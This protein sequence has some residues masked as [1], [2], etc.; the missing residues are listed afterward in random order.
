MEGVYNYDI[1]SS[2]TTGLRQ[3]AE[4]LQAVGCSVDTEALDKY[5]ERGGKDWV[6]DN[7][8]LD[9]NLV[10]RVEHAI[11]FGAS[12]PASMRQA[13]YKKYK[14]AWGM[15]EIAQHVDEFYEGRET[16]DR[17]LKDLNE[18]FGPQV[19]MIEDLAQG[20]LN[21]YWSAHSQ[22][23]G[24]GMGRFMRNHAGITFCKH[25]HKEKIFSN[26]EVIGYRYGHEARARV[27]AWY[28]Q[29]LE[30]AYIHAITVLSEEY[31]YEVMANE[32]DGC[33]TIGTIPDEAKRR[34]RDLSGFRNAVLTDKRFED[35]DDVRALCEK[36]NLEYPSPPLENARCKKQ[37]E[38]RGANE[39]QPK[40]EITGGSTSVT[41]R[42]DSNPPKQ[43]ESAS[44]GAT[45][46]GDGPSGTSSQNGEKHADRAQKHPEQTAEERSA[47]R[48][49]LRP[50]LNETTLGDGSR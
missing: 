25:E 50:E 16:K 44:G 33:I 27:M 35:E 36:H 1:K 17:V 31:E 13:Y 40:P 45:P 28:L 19:Q 14:T 10:K 15:P 5:I 32:H 6:T 3:L 38:N 2:Q 41:S 39:Q 48:M 23:G 12:I 47:H 8:D 46:A 7:Y 11:K 20:L 30:A 22:T 24:R 29:G 21:D 42:T 26:G 9:R 34:A 43:S 37:K 49:G 4:D 18:V